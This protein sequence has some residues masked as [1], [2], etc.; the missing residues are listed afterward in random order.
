MA[1][2]LL[3][4]A[5][6]IVQGQTANEV[7]KKSLPSVVV[8]FNENSKGKS[9]SL[10]SGFFVRSDVIATNYHVVKGA[11]RLYAKLINQ[12]RLYPIKKILAYDSD[13]DIALLRISGVEASPLW[14]GNSCIMEVG[15]TVYVVG[16]PKG[17][18]GTFSQGIVSSIR[19]LNGKRYLQI[20]AAISEG[21]SGSPILN[22]YGDVVGI[23]VASL[24]EGQ[25]LNFAVSG[26]DLA[27]IIYK[28]VGEGFGVDMFAD[29][30]RCIDEGR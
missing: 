14:L 2:I 7:A 17:L 11:S 12:P 5:L 4:Y 25:N 1:F 15:D 8:L 22:E 19:K 3:L 29:I 30:A 10:G 18:E 28:T 20:T 13:K 27:A 9:I 24:K 23:A 6:S 21:S 16:N 26:Q